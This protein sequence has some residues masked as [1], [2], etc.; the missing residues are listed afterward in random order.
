[1]TQEELNS[2]H[3]CLL[4]DINKAINTWILRLVGYTVKARNVHRILAAKQLE[5]TTGR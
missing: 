2:I 5:E 1:M 3:I 4:V